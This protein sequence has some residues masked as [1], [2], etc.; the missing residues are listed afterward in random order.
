MDRLVRRHLK[1]ALVKGAKR[2]YYEK[3]Y[4]I[5]K[6]EEGITN[7]P[8][9]LNSTISP[10]DRIQKAINPLTL[11]D[12]GSFLKLLVMGGGRI[13]P[14]A[15]NLFLMPLFDSFSTRITC[16][17]PKYMVHVKKPEYFWKLKNFV[18][19]IPNLGKNWAKIEN[20]GEILKN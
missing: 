17:G 9:F 20:F 10:T 2:E 18:I 12:M 19:Q 3:E 1:K 14:P 6:E 16:M 11:L 8:V 13:S 4:I 5:Y 7:E 15:H